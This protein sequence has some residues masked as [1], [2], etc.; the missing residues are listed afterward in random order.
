MNDTAAP[1]IAGVPTDGSFDAVAACGH[2]VCTLSMTR[3]LTC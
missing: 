3:A 1:V 2:R